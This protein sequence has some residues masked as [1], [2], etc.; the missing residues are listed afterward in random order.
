M[1]RK[2]ITAWSK[3]VLTISI[4]KPQTKKKISSRNLNIYKTGKQKG[5]LFSLLIIALQVGNEIVIISI[6]KVLLF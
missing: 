2:A 5:A 1:N 4:S 6:I 3:Y